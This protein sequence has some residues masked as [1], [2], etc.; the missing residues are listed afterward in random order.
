[1]A[2]C[3]RIKKNDLFSVILGV[4]SGKS[5]VCGALLADEMWLLRFSE[6]ECVAAN[7]ETSAFRV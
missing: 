1:M 3:V 7:A 2:Y 6:E 5:I 4:K